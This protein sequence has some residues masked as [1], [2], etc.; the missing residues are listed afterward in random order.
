MSEGGS[1]ESETENNTVSSAVYS[2][3]GSSTSDSSS[4]W[5]SSTSSEG[6][7][8]TDSSNSSEETYTKM[9]GE[10]DIPKFT[11]DREGFEGWMVRWMSHGIRTKFSDVNS[12]TRHPDCPRLGRHEPKSSD[13]AM[14][15]KVKKLLK[16]NERAMADVRSAFTDNWM[17]LV[18][19]NKT[20]TT[21]DPGDPHDRNKKSYYLQGQIWLVLASLIKKYRGDSFLDQIALDKDKLT[22]II[23]KGE[24]PDKQSAR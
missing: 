20:K 15:K 2:S 14:V 22:I 19:I 6:T 9:G 23:R 11:G 1:I 10:K 12:M 5:N 8:V 21:T 16:Q 4:D 18:L 24:H 17:L 13:K 7:W 3:E